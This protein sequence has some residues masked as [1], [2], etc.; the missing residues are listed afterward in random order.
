MSE[1]RTQILVRGLPKY[2]IQISQSRTACLQQSV[3]VSR[4]PSS[5]QIRCRRIDQ[6]VSALT[7]KLLL[8]VVQMDRTTDF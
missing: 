7:V 8:P 4:R 6:A 3:L 5:G 1:R 2:F